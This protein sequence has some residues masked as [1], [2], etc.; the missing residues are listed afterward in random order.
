MLIVPISTIIGLVNGTEIY[1]LIQKG[2]PIRY[3]HVII[4][5]DLILENYDLPSMAII[6]SL[7]LGNVSFNNSDFSEICDFHNTK[8]SK[9]IYFK[10]SIF[11]RAAYFN[12][13]EFN[14][15]S[16][17]IGSD[18]GDLA[19]FRGSKFHNSAWFGDSKFENVADFRNCQFDLYAYFGGSKFKKTS[20]FEGSKFKDTALFQG[21]E[22]NESSFQYCKFDGY[23]DYRSSEIRSFIDFSNSRFNSYFYGW[24][25]LQDCFR[26]DEEA[27]LLAI[28]NL[29][30]HGQ[31]SESDDCYYT[32][33]LT[34]MSNF[35]D[36]ISLVTCGFGVRPLNTFVLGIVF[37]IL[38]GL[39]YFKLGAVR[40]LNDAKVSIWDNI[41]FSALLFF[42]LHPPKH[43]DYKESLAWI[44]LLEDIIGW[45]TMALFIVTLGNV[46]IR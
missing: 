32:Y 45:I 39:L 3:D 44:I 12:G 30:N 19:L 16:K 38:F 26:C 36:F 13:S 4:K 11:H 1:N 5:D 20:L 34:Y 22:F 9:N 10:N 7:I 18:F 2:E 6:E 29:R 42:T 23:A 41:F 28:E 21:S 37:I 33:R 17:F 25:Y 46:I 15:S 43:W 14:L 40:K 8:F 24:D 27:Y 35:A 31:L